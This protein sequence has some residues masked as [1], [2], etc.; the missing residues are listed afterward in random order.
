MLLV[1]LVA[2][3]CA[4][5]VSKPSYA[6]V[7]AGTHKK[8]VADPSKT[9]DS[10]RPRPAAATPGP[11]KLKQEDIAQAVTAFSLDV[12]KDVLRGSQSN[13]V[14]SVLG[15][16]H[17]L[18]LLQQSADPLSETAAQLEKGLHLDRESSYK[19]LPRLLVNAVTKRHSKTVLENGNNLFVNK[20]LKVKDPF[21]EKARTHYNMNVTALDFKQ[22]DSAVSA[23][24]QWVSESTHGRIPS[25]VSKT[26]VSPRTSMVLASAM[27]FRG[28]WQHMFD[29]GKT[30]QKLFSADPSRNVTVFMMQQAGDF[31]AGEL[32]D[33]DAQWLELPFDGDH[34]SML[35]LLPNKRHGLA[36]VVQGLEASHVTAM[37]SGTGP[38]R[39]T[40][41]LMPRF[42]LNSD[43][44]LTKTLKQLGMSALFGREARLRGISDTPIAVSD[45][46]HKAEMKVDEQGATAS[47]ASAVLVNTLSLVSFSEDMKFYADHPFLAIIA[48]RT[49]KVPV[50][51]GRVAYPI[52]DF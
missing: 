52:E 30:V 51:V 40:V 44:S 5:E 50:F 11:V 26:S 39:R 43:V 48:D 49:T 16:A 20:D 14:V 34:F 21:L 12:A 2:S 8:P 23:I 1:L 45:V 31:R 32:A 33:L 13:A 22:L 36:E 37:L 6:S 27:Y 7:V 28:V 47:A 42:Q 24:N 15:V 29:A 18:S 3:C 4:G 10:L 35:L 17:L 41:L 19:G 46:L 38:L 25:I 9:Q